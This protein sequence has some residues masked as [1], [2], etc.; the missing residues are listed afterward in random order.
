M[1]TLNEPL[2]PNQA[3]VFLG[4]REVMVVDLALWWTDPSFP[5]WTRTAPKKLGF[6]ATI[7]H[8]R[9][10]RPTT[11]RL[12]LLEALSP[13]P[14]D[15]NGFSPSALVRMENGLLKQAREALEE[16]LSCRVTVSLEQSP[17]L[18]MDP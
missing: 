18:R 3:Q 1:A 6:R 4:H 5:G 10:Y 9:Q 13:L 17:L 16:Q 2:D 12:S 8:M 7:S 11:Y 15:S 14:Q